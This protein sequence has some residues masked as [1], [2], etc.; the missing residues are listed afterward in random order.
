VYL[1][2]NCVFEIQLPEH[3]IQISA[4]RPLNLDT[5]YVLNVSGVDIF[6]DDNFGFDTK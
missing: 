6:W 1:K 4:S 5:T 3:F 2:I